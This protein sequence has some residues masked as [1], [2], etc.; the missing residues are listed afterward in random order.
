M[1][2]FLSLF[3]AFT[4]LTLSLLAQNDRFY[5]SLN[6]LSGTTLYGFF[7]ETR[8]FLWIPTYSGLNRF[9]G[10]NFKVYQQD[11]NDSTTLNSTNTNTVF[12]DSRGNLWIGTNFGLNLYNYKK[13]CFRQVHLKVKNKDFPITVVSILEDKDKKLWLITSHGLVHF[14]PQTW[15]YTFF[16]HQF[17]ND[18]SP[19]Y[20]K[21]NQAVFDQKGNL[22]IGTDDNNVLVFETGTSRFLN[23]REYTGIDFTFPDRTVLV[24]HQNS[25]HQ[26]IFGT[27]R[28]G[29]VFFDPAKGIFKH[30]GYSENP[31]N[32][33]DG[34]IYSITT[35]RR[36]TVWVGTERNGLKTYDAEKNQITDANS[37]IDLPNIQKGKVH[38]YE[39]R[40]GDMWFGIQFR[41][42][43][44]K[45]SS[46]KPFH[47]LG[48]SK[49]MNL[50]LSHYIV[51]S[52]VKDHEGT[53]WVGT[54]G[55][56]INLLEKGS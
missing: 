3:L 36:G 39:D 40:S 18:G 22:L 32:L 42:I 41:G 11:V 6:G 8:G 26:I 30:A 13:D 37:L 29:L 47:T 34:G 24:V 31:V 28:A 51:K 50:N 16:N 25:K 46:V 12:E 20:S 5:S 44:H 15:E 49:K 4:C 21:Y 10:Y 55:G 38:C 1:S 23:L 48:N 56:G 43:Y 52:I 7:Q 33:L 35:D 45:I 2:R 9:D 27:L 53:L 19:A 54:D 17:N 14:N